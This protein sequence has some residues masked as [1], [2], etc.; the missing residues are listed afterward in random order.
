MS[1]YFDLVE[2]E[3][4]QAVR[5]RAHLPLHARLRL[6]H[7][8]ALLLALACVVVGGPAIAAAAGAFRT[9]SRVP[10]TVPA[11]PQAFDGVAIAGSVRVLA[12]RVADPDGGPS[13]GLRFDRTTRGLLCVQPGRVVN[14]EIGVLG[15]D[16]AFADD[17][18]FHPFSDNY[19]DEFGCA[20]ID[21]AGHAFVAPSVFNTP[22]S[23]LSESCAPNYL[24]PTPGAG[25][26]EVA[27]GRGP[28]C[29]PG[30]LRDLSYGMLGP[31][32]VSY[33]YT[34]A[35]GKLVTVPTAGPDGAYLVVSMAPDHCPSRIVTYGGRPHR[36]AAFCL[37]TFIGG[38]PA[39]GELIR[40]VTYRSGRSCSVPPALT[41][42]LHAYH[43]PAVGY[44]APPA[45]RLSAVQVASAVIV[46]NH[47][48]QYF[49][50]GRRA[51]HPCGAHPT[52]GSHVGP[53]PRYWV[54][55]VDFTARVAVHSIAERY[56]ILM[57]YP[58]A[59]NPGCQI[60]GGVGP[61]TEDL[62]AGQRVSYQDPVP[63]TCSGT[64]HVRVSFRQPGGPALRVGSA[65]FTLPAR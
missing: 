28:L 46:R 13:W 11:T 62:R 56:S 38:N 35:A 33:S 9:G 31:D 39:P 61:T 51:T 37:G 34:N 6:R 3:L 5:R 65:T 2:Q 57:Q 36:I 16:N 1:D 27:V 23:G 52:A 63:E 22:A 47:G 25:E 14:G 45:Q 8:R 53:G 24:A 32:A 12:L 20:G 48:L 17:N 18:R 55:D 15:I 44:V 40:K 29:P 50:I 26:R 42:A 54:L 64:F 59:H 60:G 21:G 7:S 43:C 19:V 41:A 4:C 58:P 10:A 49:C 30:S